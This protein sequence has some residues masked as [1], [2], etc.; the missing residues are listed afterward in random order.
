ME[1]PYLE[2]AKRYRLAL[3]AGAVGDEL[4]QFFSKDV[5]QEEFPNR[6]VP[7]GAKRDLAA[8]LE[9]AARGK[10]V[11]QKQRYQVLNAIED[12]QTVALE[13]QWIGT[14]AVPVGTLPA[15]GEM[16]ARF[17]VFLDFRG[18]KI[19]RQRN[20]DCFEAW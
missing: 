20:Y 4:A 6:L 16:R 3:E 10:Q 11:M 14:L 8:L 2:I 7:N 18:D 13:V 9:G 15:G 1:R 17:A 12:G 5:V 19:V